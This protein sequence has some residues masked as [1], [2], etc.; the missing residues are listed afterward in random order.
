MAIPAIQSMMA[1]LLELAG[2]G[3]AHRLRDAVDLLSDRPGHK[4]GR[5]AHV[6]ES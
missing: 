5:D 3:H 2:D 6:G 4:D 1:P